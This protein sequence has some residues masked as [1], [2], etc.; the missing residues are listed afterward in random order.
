MKKK[1]IE[2]GQIIPWLQ[3]PRP[4]GKPVPLFL[5][6]LALC[7]TFF[8]GVY[9]TEDTK[10]FVNVNNVENLAKA[11][12]RR[13]AWSDPSTLPGLRFKAGSEG[14]G[15]LFVDFFSVA[16]AKFSSSSLCGEV[17]RLGE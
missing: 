14:R 13:L 9:K 11:C 1:T 3:L 16:L 5:L 15:G 12:K 17:A 8:M 2:R 6:V 7:G 4:L 10:P